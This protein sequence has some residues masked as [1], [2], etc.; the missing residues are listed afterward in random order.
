MTITDDDF[1]DYANGDYRPAAEGKLV[2]AGALDERTDASTKDLDGNPRLSDGIDIG[3]YE[4]QHT[5]MT[6][7]FTA[8]AFDVGYAPATATFTASAENAP[9]D[10]SFD[11]NFGDGTLASYTETEISH[12]YAESGTYTITVTAVSGAERSK[13]MTRTVKI[14][15]KIQRVGEGGHA[16]IQ[17]AL[18][19]AVAGCEVILA[20]G[21]YEVTSPIVVNKALVDELCSSHFEQDAAIQVTIARVQEAVAHHFDVRIQD[22]RGKARQAE[23]TLARQVAMYLSRELTGKSLPVIATAFD[24][25]HPTVIHSL[26]I[27]EKKAAESDEFRQVLADISRRLTGECR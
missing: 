6:V 15:D 19:E 5:D 23:I 22:L 21:T 27:V 24:K 4:Y 25:T 11:V 1:A 8:P 7:A 18:D 13:P 3:C 17:E 14:V 26:R 9:G 20:A 16:T 2:D 10:V 12:V